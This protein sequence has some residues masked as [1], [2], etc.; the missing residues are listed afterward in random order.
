MD[1]DLLSPRSK[2][3]RCDIRDTKPNWRRASLVGEVFNRL[4]VIE[5]VGSNQGKCYWK[6]QCSC[7]KEVVANTYML[8]SGKKQSC[9][10]LASEL[11]ALRNMT[12]GKSD[13]PLYGAWLKIAD[14]CYNP[15]CKC[16]RHYGGRGIEMCQRWRDS[17]EAFLSDMG[18]RPCGCEIDRIDNN[19]PY[20]PEN[21]H[22][23]THEKN[24]RNTRRNRLVTID[25]ETKCV[26]EWCELY[27]IPQSVVGSRMNSYGW[28]D[29]KAI[30][31]PCHPTKG[32]KTKPS[33]REPEGKQ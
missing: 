6:C 14:R 30:T 22:W 3:R 18:E 20:S 33:N 2:V 21:C 27:G 23:V 31:T 29:V 24:M 15:N 10:C 12:H 16:Y 1:D 11:L 7:G 8:R 25:G 17:F 5:A 13:H 32:R 28:D 19:G 9:G 26:A 4:T